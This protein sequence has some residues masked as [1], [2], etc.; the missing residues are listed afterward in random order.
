MLSDKLKYNMMLFIQA[1][2][3]YDEQLL[4]EL[5][6]DTVEN[7]ESNVERIVEWVENYSN[8]AQQANSNR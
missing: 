4:V 2:D 6:S 5:Q 3:S 8:N 7:M 1:R